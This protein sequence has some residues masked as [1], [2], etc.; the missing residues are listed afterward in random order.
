MAVL[1]WSSTWRSSP[2]GSLGFL[3]AWWPFDLAAGFQQGM[4]HAGKVEALKA[5][6]PKYTES[7]LCSVGQIRPLPSLDSRGGAGDFTSWWRASWSLCKSACR[8]RD[9]AEAILGSRSTVKFCVLSLLHM[10]SPMM[11]VL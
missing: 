11:S 1:R 3:I 5:W 7:L 8:M 10:P 9:N 4:F 6:A 2:L